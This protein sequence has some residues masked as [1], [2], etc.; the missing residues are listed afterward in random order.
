MLDSTVQTNEKFSLL[1][2][3]WEFIYNA[4]YFKAIINLEPFNY[5]RVVKFPVIMDNTTVTG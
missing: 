1:C 3:S 2:Y 5:A 4:I